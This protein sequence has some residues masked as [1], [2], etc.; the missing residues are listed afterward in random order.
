MKGVGQA[1]SAGQRSPSSGSDNVVLYVASHYFGV[2]YV[3][4]KFLCTLFTGA[5]ICIDSLS[6]YF[7]SK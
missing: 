5:E 4:L 1:V 7:E 3:V 6:R 2:I